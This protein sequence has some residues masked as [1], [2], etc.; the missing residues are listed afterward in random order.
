MPVEAPQYPVSLV[1]EGRP[2][3]VVGGGRVAARKVDG[4]LACGAQVHVV[5]PR[6]ADELKQRHGVTVEERPYRDGDVAGYRLVVSATDD[7]AVNRAVYDEAEA[8]GVWVNSA[9]DPA[10]CTFTLP[11]VLRRGPMTVA[12][13]TG[14]HSPGLAAWLRRRLEEEIGPEY[15]T[16]LDLLAQARTEAQAEGRSTE[17]VDWQSAL[18]SE[19]LEM[20]RAGRVNE[21]RER[22]RSW[23]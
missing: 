14:G 3:L 18:D 9:D 12:V 16:L 11:S 23:L 22:L 19:I 1:L 6:V 13:S 21:A 20:I 10:N 17:G 4:L 7:A 2:V 15:E 5:A 8:A